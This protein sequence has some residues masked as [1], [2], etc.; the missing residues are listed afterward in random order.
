M[1]VAGPSVRANGLSVPWDQGRRGYAIRPAETS[2]AGPPVDQP[3]LFTVQADATGFV[4]LAKRRVVERTQ[5]WNERAR[6]L[7]MHHDCLVSASEAG[8]WL[9]EAR[10]LP[11]RLTT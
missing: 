7:M 9:T 2:V 3:H 4:V 11:R 6:H 10:M 8:A 1:G 5:A